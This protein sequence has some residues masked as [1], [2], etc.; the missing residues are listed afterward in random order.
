MYMTIFK[1]HNILKINFTNYLINF[2]CSLLFN[3]KI[4]N[5]YP[6]I[7]LKIIIL[8]NIALL[9]CHVKVHA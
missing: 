1:I 9:K 3:S 6:I 2:L 8:K 7:K 5:N 4:K